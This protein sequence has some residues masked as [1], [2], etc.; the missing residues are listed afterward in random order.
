MGLTIKEGLAVGKPVVVTNSGF[1]RI[2]NDEFAQRRWFLVEMADRGVFFDVVF[3]NDLC[4]TD[5][6]DR[7]L[8]RYDVML[9]PDTCVFD[10]TLTEV[11]AAFAR[12]PRPVIGRIHNDRLMLD[13][14]CLDDEPTFMAQLARFGPV[15]R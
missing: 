3:D 4:R 14:R 6:P 13:L 11:V 10:D 1:D 12:L 9:L 7:A 2:R 5:D 15:R 8:D